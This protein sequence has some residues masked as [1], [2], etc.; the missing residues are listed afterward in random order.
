[1]TL[2]RFIPNHTDGTAVTTANL[3]AT[4]GGKNALIVNLGSGENN[5]TIQYSSD[6]PSHDINPIKFY[7]ESTRSSFLRL[8][9]DGAHMSGSLS[10]YW[11]VPQAL[12]AAQVAVSMRNASGYIGRIQLSSNGQIVVRDAADVNRGATATGLVQANKW[13]R[14]DMTMTVNTATTGSYALQIFEGDDETPIGTCS[15]AVAD[16]GTA[17][18]VAVDFGAPVSVGAANAP[19]LTQYF[20]APSLNDGA[21]T[22]IGPWIVNTLSILHTEVGGYCAVDFRPSTPSGLT[23]TISPSAGVL[24]PTPGLFLVQQTSDTQSFTVTSTDGSTSVDTAVS[25]PAA[26]AVDSLRM[27]T[28][29]SSD[30][31]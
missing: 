2:L 25:V 31:V 6:L 4:P 23:H 12:A 28:Y 19:G 21:T 26:G 9:F 16:F 8:P 10:F 11:R 1:M 18:L 29:D 7:T 5:N 20:L 24:E 30:W 13:L 17:P 22:Q 27:R 15:S 3:V 14:I